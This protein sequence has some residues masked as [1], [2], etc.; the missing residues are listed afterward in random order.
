MRQLNLNL[1][2]H[3]GGITRQILLRNGLFREDYGTTTR[4]PRA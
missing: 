4:R 1:F 2:I 3:P